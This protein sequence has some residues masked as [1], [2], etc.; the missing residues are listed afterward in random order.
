M[1]L[2]GLYDERG[3]KEGRKEK[4]LDDDGKDQKQWDQSDTVEKMNMIGNRGTALLYPM[5]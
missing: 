1:V 5:Y 4:G 3:R 2:D